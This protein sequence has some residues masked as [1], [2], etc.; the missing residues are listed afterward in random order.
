MQRSRW[1]AVSAHVS[2]HIRI[3]TFICV[4]HKSMLLYIYILYIDIYG[5]QSLWCSAITLE[6]HGFECI[7]YYTSVYC[8]CFSRWL[9]FAIACWMSLCF[10]S[11]SLLA[12][13]HATFSRATVQPASQT[14][15]IGCV[16]LSDYHMM[17]AA[18]MHINT[19]I[20]IF[21]HVPTYIQKETSTMNHAYTQHSFTFS[22]LRSL[23]VMHT[24]IHANTH[25][26]TH[27]E[28]QLYMLCHVSRRKKNPKFRF[29]VSTKFFSL[30]NVSSWLWRDFDFRF[31]F[32]SLL[33]SKAIWNWCDLPK[34]MQEVNSFLHILFWFIGF[35]FCFW[36]QHFGF[37]SIPRYSMCIVQFD[38]WCAF[39]SV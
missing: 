33:R 5:K 27:E 28:T 17:C 20:G 24:H 1:F 3:Y 15:S 7:F 4:W 36:L 22:L 10:C 11:S 12:W 23:A 9:P 2:I 14:V 30:I 29:L 8:Y 34:L 37:A 38:Q 35:H 13:H 19:H 25:T 18:A 32:S 16:F 6:V 31:F 21:I 39:A 26:L